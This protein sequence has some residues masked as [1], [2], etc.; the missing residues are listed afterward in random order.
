MAH[1]EVRSWLS[2]SPYDMVV[3]ETGIVARSRWPAGSK[4]DTVI[5]WIPELPDALTVLTAT[6]FAYDVLGT[7][8]E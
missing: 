5:I 2:L 1:L 6:G 3:T 4:V 7:E 8:A